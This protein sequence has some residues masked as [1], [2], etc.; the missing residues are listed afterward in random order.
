[1]PLPCE[2]TRLYEHPGPFATA[3]LDATRTTE[4]GAEQVRLRWQTLRSTLLHAGADEATVAALDDSAGDRVLGEQGRVLVGAGGETLL[5]A[6]L[7]RPPLRPLARWAPLPHVMPYLA[8]QG[9]RIPHVVVLADLEG[10]DIS[11]SSGTTTAV[12]GSHGDPRRK[13]STADWSQR[14]FRQWVANNW[15]ADAREVAAAVA[16]HAARIGAT[17]VV[18]AGDPRAYGSLRSELPAFLDRDV[19][20]V[21]LSEGGRDPGALHRELDDAIHG[22]LLQR[23][24]RESA[25]VLDRLGAAREQGMVVTGAEAVVAAVR[26]SQVD[27]ALLVEDPSSTLHA[28]IGPQPLQLGLVEDELSAMGVPAPQRDRLDAAL[29]RALAGSDASLLTVPPDDATL[30]GGIAALL[31]YTDAATPV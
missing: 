8:Q 31:R 21:P 29:I 24:L 25:R 9:L 30:P 20:I 7:P 17:V 4:L 2:V 18:L 27:T 1:M 3:Y 22:V 26:R 15:A 19:E 5:A 23:A 6:S 12:K 14:H 28:W 13:T 16:D 10:A 11:T